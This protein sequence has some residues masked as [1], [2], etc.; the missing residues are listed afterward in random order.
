[1]FRMFRIQHL[2]KALS[3]K[4]RGHCSQLFVCAFRFILFV[5]DY[6]TSFLWLSSK[7][8]YFLS[9]AIFL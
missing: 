6:K 4:G 5:S 3:V 9:I 2:K 8:V 7:K 1:M